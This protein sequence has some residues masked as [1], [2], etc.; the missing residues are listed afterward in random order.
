MSSA[1]TILKICVTIGST[2]FELLSAKGATTELIAGLT[3]IVGG[4]S[5]L[6]P[7]IT[8]IHVVRIIAFF[9]FE[10]SVG[11]YFPSIGMLRSRIVPEA[12]RSTIM[13]IFRIPL[14]L[15][16]AIVLQNVRASPLLRSFS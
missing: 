12:H 11:L 7:A 9:A 5:L 8:K 16:V 10:F 2:T 3:F 15:I 14:N 6:I 4:I 1:F 13:T